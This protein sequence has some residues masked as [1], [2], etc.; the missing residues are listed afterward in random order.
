MKKALIL[1]GLLT[2]CIAVWAIPKDVNKVFQGIEKQIHMKIETVEVNVMDII[3]VQA[4]DESP[5]V[6]IASPV[7]TSEIFVAEK[8][9]TIG[10]M[11]Y[12]FSWRAIDKLF[13]SDQL[14]RIKLIWNYIEGMPEHRISIDQEAPIIIM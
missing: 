2:A 3:S 4:Q 9:R 11:N 5:G 8:V 12:P 6:L 10:L 14:T 13:Y 1:F 7:K